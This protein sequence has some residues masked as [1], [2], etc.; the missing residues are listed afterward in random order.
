MTQAVQELLWRFVPDLQR[1]KL[2]VQAGTSVRP[3][4]AFTVCIVPGVVTSSL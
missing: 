2:R 3:T 1:D 4:Q